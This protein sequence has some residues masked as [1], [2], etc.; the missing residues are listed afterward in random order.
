MR[1]AR[2]P[3]LPRHPFKLRQVQRRHPRQPALHEHLQFR[4][5][6]RG[7]VEAAELDEDQAWEGGEVAGVG[8]GAALGADVAVE[9]AAG[10]GD[11]AEGL[12]L[13]GGEGD[14]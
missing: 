11:V 1:A 10:V 12:G 13:A 5:D 7:V 3:A 6:T 2:R 9:R 4:G 8:A 14:C